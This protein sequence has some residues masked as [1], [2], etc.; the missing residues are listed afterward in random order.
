MTEDGY[1]TAERVGDLSVLRFRRR[2]EHPRDLVWAARSPST[3]TR[4]DGS[5]R[6]SRVH[7]SPAPPCTSRS[8]EGEGEPFDGQM[9]AFDP[10]SLMELRW[11]DDLLRFELEADGS[12]CLFKRP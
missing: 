7:G 9:T 4:R 8:G 5:P 1:G 2:L 6:P 12:G 11:S 3:S 10:P